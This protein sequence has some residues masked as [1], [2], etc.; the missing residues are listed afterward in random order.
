MDE[1]NQQALSLAFKHA[2]AKTLKIQLLGIT[3]KYTELQT[4]ELIKTLARTKAAEEGDE[5]KWPDHVKG[6]RWYVE[7]LIAFSALKPKERLDHEYERAFP[8]VAEE[9]EMLLALE[10]MVEE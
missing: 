5:E 3:P 10:A 9:D 1:R 8:D 7:D 6:Q 4:D 2:K